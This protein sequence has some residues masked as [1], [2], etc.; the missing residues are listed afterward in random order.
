[1]KP[2]LTKEAMEPTMG[3]NMKHH[4]DFISQHETGGHKHHSN[5]YKA[6]AAGHKPHAEHV[7]AMC[8]GGMAKGKK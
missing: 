6:H 7:K 2:Q 4:D 5:M 3:P 1:M 8:G